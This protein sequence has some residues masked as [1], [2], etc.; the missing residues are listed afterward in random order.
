MEISKNNEKSSM[1]TVQTAT[2][3]ALGYKLIP[4]ALFKT[5]IYSLTEILQ[6][7]IMIYNKIN[8]FAFENLVAI[9][10]IQNELVWTDFL[11]LE[12]Y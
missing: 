7:L 8:Y 12:Q 11:Y 4:R 10:M 6:Y 3:L 1:D 2:H 9:H 5:N